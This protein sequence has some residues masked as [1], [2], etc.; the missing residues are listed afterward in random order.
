M[1]NKNFVIICILFLIGCTETDNLDSKFAHYFQLLNESQDRHEISNAR[2][3][4]ERIFNALEAQGSKHL[5]DYNY[6][7]YSYRAAEI[8]AATPN[9]GK[10]ED[11]IRLRLHPRNNAV[12]REKYQK[13]EEPQTFSSMNP[14][15]HFALVRALTIS[16]KMLYSRDGKNYNFGDLINA[17]AQLEKVKEGSRL[18]RLAVNLEDG[19]CFGVSTIA[20]NLV[21][22][23]PNI[24]PQKIIEKLN[25]NLDR[26]LALQMQHN[27]STT[28]YN[29][30]Q[31][32]AAAAFINNY[33]SGLRER[34]LLGF[35]L[36]SEVKRF[37]TELLEKR[38]K[39]SKGRTFVARVSFSGGDKVGHAVAIQVLQDGREFR[40]IDNNIGVLSF[41]T[42]EEFLEAFADYRLAHYGESTKPVMK[43]LG[44]YC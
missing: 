5:A 18:Y 33:S 25:K 23:D 40:I 31:L 19:L 1:K 6:L 27:I 34:A 2:R 4:V 32:D 37:M 12:F 7:L 13:A 11:F 43:V 22:K 30:A 20:N 9:A 38:I 44:N 21:C 16:Q 8:A 36:R 17:W 14:S 3:E 39:K 15:H 24:K 26:I 42:L 29:N 41:S 28:V 10:L 35:V